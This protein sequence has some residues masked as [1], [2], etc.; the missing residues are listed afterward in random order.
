MSDIWPQFLDRY[1]PEAGVDGG[2]RLVR[3]VLNAEPDRWQRD[4]IAALR[5][6]ER[7]ISIR[8]CHGPG[9]TAVAA[10]AAWDRLLVYL[11]QLT[12]ATA[13]SKTQLEDALM[14]EMLIWHGRMKK[15]LRDLY[16]FKTY[17][18]ELKS[19][20][21]ESFFT[22]TTARAEAPEAL[23]GKHSDNLLLIVDEA[24]GV[25]EQVFEAGAGSMSS[26]NATT[27]LL[28]NPTRTSG[29][30]FDT[31]RKNSD[32]WRTFKVGIDDSPRVTESFRE[33]IGSQYGFDSDAYR[34]RVL[35]EFPKAD[36]D[37]VIPYE[38]AASACEREIPPSSTAPIVWGIDP[39][40]QGDDRTG[41]VARQGRIV[42]RVEEW[43][44]PDL[45]VLAG[46]I[47]HMYD[48]AGVG[49][50]PEWILVDEIGMG[51]G[52]LDRLREVELPVR[53]VNVAESA[54]AEDR[55]MRLRDELWWKVREWL[56]AM[57][58]SLP[59]TSG[60]R[61]DLNEKLLS[62]LTTPKYKFESSG[63]LKVEAKSDMKKR[64]HKSPNLADALCLTF[65]VNPAA[66][67]H[68]SSAQYGRT[69]WKKPLRRKLKGIV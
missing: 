29:F 14:K 47:K 51:Y 25:A 41:M 7:H 54:S 3:E 21:A 13:P 18:I 10:W 6:G 15:W 56:S 43:E 42:T 48:T 24:S 17:R 37:T 65:A 32:L 45:M 5:E 63:K 39:A 38:L 46:K 44:I 33:Y 26:E 22:A 61:D 55:Y 34:V 11:P 4:V 49:E 60:R 50:R 53:G 52:L 12:A 28:S 68:G 27:L 8:A 57:D 69:S 19:A 59:A 35:G 58:V 67:R 16:S 36:A 66:L 40:R 2:I 30:F 23:Q 64:G 31:H 20:P 9:K 1:G 62:E